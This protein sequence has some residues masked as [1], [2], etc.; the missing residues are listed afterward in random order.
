MRVSR[1][2]TEAASG[3]ALHAATVTATSSLKISAIPE[4]FTLYALRYFPEIR[5]C[6]WSGVDDSVANGEPHKLGD[7][8]Q[9]EL[10]HDIRPV[11]VDGFH[12]HA[13]D[14]GNI[15]VGL[16]FREELH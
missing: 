13:Q 12:A 4:L 6:R 8:V 15:L 14:T 2:K 5:A 16:R 10:P 1:T 11:C 3:R 9:I 7:R